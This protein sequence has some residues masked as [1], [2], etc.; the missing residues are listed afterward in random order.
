MF[1]PFSTF[2]FSRTFSLATGQ[3]FKSVLT[4]LEMIKKKEAGISTKPD[5]MIP[6]GRKEP[7]KFEQ[8]YSRYEQ[9]GL[10]GKTTGG[11]QINTLGSNTDHSLNAL[12]SGVKRYICSLLNF[13]DRFF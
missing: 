13:I 9:E 3:D 1:D 6:V 10:K 12:V 11:F 5:P 4:W 2:S 8:G 7:R